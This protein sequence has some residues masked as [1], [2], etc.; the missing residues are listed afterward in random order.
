MGAFTEE[1]PSNLGIGQ[2]GADFSAELFSPGYV[3]GAPTYSIDNDPIEQPILQ[4]EPTGDDSTD[5]VTADPLPTP[6]PKES[7]PSNGRW[8]Y[9][10]GASPLKVQLHNG[11]GILAIWLP[12]EPTQTITIASGMAA[13]GAIYTTSPSSGGTQTVA[14]EIIAIPSGHETLSLSASAPFANSIF[15]LVSGEPYTPSKTFSSIIGTI[16]TLQSAVFIASTGTAVQETLVTHSGTTSIYVLAYMLSYWNSA[17]AGSNTAI[18]ANMTE[19]NFFLIMQASNNNVSVYS[20]GNGGAVLF[21]IP[22]GQDLVLFVA[23]STGNNSEV[24]G[25]ITFIQA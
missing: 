4:S 16:Q 3:F 22:P 10:S 6:E 17:P 19:T 24:T 20:E 5:W 13:S 21:I 23:A 25:Q 18:L 15:V 8:Y 7:G 1:E 11:A 14:S 2:T 12:V 9:W